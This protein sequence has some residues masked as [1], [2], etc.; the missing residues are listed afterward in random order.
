MKPSVD[1]DGIP[2]GAVVGAVVDFIVH[3]HFV[4]HMLLMVSYSLPPFD[5]FNGVHLLKDVR[6]IVPNASICSFVK[7]GL[8]LASNLVKKSGLN[9]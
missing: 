8:P 2:V 6:S 3:L 5:S 4:S 9:M 7:V 1:V